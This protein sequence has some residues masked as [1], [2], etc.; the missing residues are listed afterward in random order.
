MHV[1]KKNQS[2]CFSHYWQATDLLLLSFQRNTLFLK[3]LS[4][5]AAAAAAA[6]DVAGVD[7][8]KSF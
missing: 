7:A 2:V 1:T 3:A 8:T 6:V 5:A 4:A